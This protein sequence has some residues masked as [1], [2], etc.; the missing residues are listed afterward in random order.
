[1]GGV[2][3]VEEPVDGVGAL[4]VPPHEVPTDVV[5]VN[6]PQFTIAV[7][8]RE[9]HRRVVAPRA[10]QLVVTPVTDHVRA[11]E[12]ASRPKLVR[13]TRSHFPSERWSVGTSIPFRV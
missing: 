4:A 13:N 3:D 9:R 6:E 11:A 8:N 7:T 1:M 10:R 12:R 2:A 5:D